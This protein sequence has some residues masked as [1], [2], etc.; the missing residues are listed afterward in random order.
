[1]SV[2]DFVSRTWTRRNGSLQAD[3]KKCPGWQSFFNL[4]RHNWHAACGTLIQGQLRD[5]GRAHC[6]RRVTIIFLGHSLSCRN[7]VKE[8]EHPSFTSTL[9][10]AVQ[11]YS[12]MRLANVK[13]VA[14]GSYPY[15]TDRGCQSTGS[16]AS[17]WGHRGSSTQCPFRHRRSFT[18]HC[19]LRTPFSRANS[20][21]SKLA[22]EVRAA[23][24]L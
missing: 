6:T 21:N 17:T 18:A 13:L 4:R 2:T 1:M 7:A 19:A 8:T 24:A 5:F 20:Q 15:C 23:Q 9:Q 10:S 12:N 3:M 22:R 11:L 14:R 16:S